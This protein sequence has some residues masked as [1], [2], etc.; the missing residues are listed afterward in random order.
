MKKFYISA[1]FL[2]LGWV[3]VFGHTGIVGDANNDGKFNEF[4]PQ[5]IEHY[6]DNQAT[7]DD[8]GH[9]L[10]DVASPCGTVDFEDARQMVLAMQRRSNSA[11]SQCHDNVKIGDEVELPHSDDRDNTIELA[12]DKNKNF[13]LD[14]TEILDA[15]GY[16]ILGGQAPGTEEF[17]NDRKILELI[18][19]WITGSSLNTT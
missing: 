5:R 17:I 15:I 16:W 7:I 3:S 9:F 12:F 8:T 4:D 11:P 1:C 6:F 13:K 2:M 14:D 18:Q 10:A 19:L